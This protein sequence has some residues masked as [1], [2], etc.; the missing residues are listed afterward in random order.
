MYKGTTWKSWEV[1]SLEQ[2]TLPTHV[3]I[4]QR[5]TD[6]QSSYKGW[7]RKSYYTIDDCKLNSFHL[8]GNLCEMGLEYITRDCWHQSL[9]NHWSL[10]KTKRAMEK[11]SFPFTKNCIWNVPFHVTKLLQFW[12]LFVSF[13][14]NT[15]PTIF[16]FLSSATKWSM[17]LH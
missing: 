17:V 9:L 8:H 2:E 5:S 14:Y 6:I 1:Y 3:I 7:G 13:D 12:G 11:D 4:T 16:P 15:L 10:F